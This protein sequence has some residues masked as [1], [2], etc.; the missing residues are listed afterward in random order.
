M[1]LRKGK[2]REVISKNISE[3]KKS[4]R[5]HDV[6]VAVALS[7]AGK[8][9]KRR[10][11]RAQMPPPQEEASARLMQSAEDREDSTFGGNSRYIVVRDS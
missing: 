9:R 10:K 7:V 3:L 4:G 8:S 6:A 1:P 5:P 2:S 11:V